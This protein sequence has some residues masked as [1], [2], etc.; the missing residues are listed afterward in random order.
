VHGYNQV[1]SSTKFFHT[2]LGLLESIKQKYEANRNITNTLEQTEAGPEQD[3][4][5]GGDS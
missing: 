4:S 5:K 2:I 1:N 3:L